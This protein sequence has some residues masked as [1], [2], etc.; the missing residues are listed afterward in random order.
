[1]ANNEF[2]GHDISTIANEG[3]TKYRFCDYGGTT[4]VEATRSS[5]ADSG[6]VPEGIVGETVASGSPAA[7][8]Y[9][10]QGRLEVDGSGT[11]IVAGTKLMPSAGNDGI[12]IDAPA[13][14]LNEYGA[15]AIDPST[16]AGDIIRVKIERGIVPVS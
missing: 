1:M 2:N 13:A 16:A 4:T 6:D 12:G 14:S 7:I 11:A 3:L 8:F 5:I 10:G 15:V 9:D